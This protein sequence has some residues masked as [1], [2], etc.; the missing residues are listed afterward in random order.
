[1]EGFIVSV[2]FRIEEEFGDFFH[3][4]LQLHKLRAGR[5]CLYALIINLFLKV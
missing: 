1:M 5:S 4:M 3:F 2:L